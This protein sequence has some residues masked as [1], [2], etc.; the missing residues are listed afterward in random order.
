M[1]HRGLWLAA[2]GLLAPVAVA[3]QEPAQR[4]E[5]VQAITPVTAILEHRAELG[6]TAD[7]IARLE[8]VDRRLRERIAPVREQMREARGEMPRPGARGERGA[9]GQ[10]V[11][12]APRPMS[13]EQRAAA[14]E[15]MD[16]ARAR[17]QEM[18]PELEELRESRR[19]A[20]DE[21][22][23]VLTEEQQ[24][25]LRELM[26]E[27]RPAPRRPGGEERRDPRGGG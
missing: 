27:R 19:E 23:E 16:A 25:R 21:V 4:G 24:G 13:P 22:R 8:A 11:P 5:A 6:L 14:R 10:R 12:R 3:A 15:R 26:R 20:M 18:R 9:R 7:Q 17:M 1:R 2:V